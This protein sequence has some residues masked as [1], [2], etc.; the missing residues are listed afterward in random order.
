MIANTFYPLPE[1]QGRRSRASGKV[2]RLPRERE[3]SKRPGGLRYG[4]P[5]YFSRMREPRTFCVLRA[6]RKLGTS[7]SIS[8][9]Y[10]DSAGVFCW[11][12]YRICSL[13][14]SE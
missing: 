4:G 11:A 9:K 7:L 12:L 14:V 10:D 13:N 8:S 1:P 3:A 6:F 5:G 2:V